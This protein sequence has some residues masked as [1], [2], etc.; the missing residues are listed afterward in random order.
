MLLLIVPHH[1]CENIWWSNSYILLPHKRNG[2]WFP[3][4]VATGISVQA[5]S[6]S[7]YRNYHHQLWRIWQAQNGICPKQRRGSEDQLLIEITTREMKNINYIAV[8]TGRL[9]VCMFR[10]CHADQAWLQNHYQVSSGVLVIPCSNVLLFC[11]PL[12][13]LFN[14]QMSG[15][16]F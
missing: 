13:R 9:P 8:Q 16:G 7:N 11:I 12:Y 2:Q 14:G 10:M 5:A 15:Q 6:Q 1:E 3:F 4:E